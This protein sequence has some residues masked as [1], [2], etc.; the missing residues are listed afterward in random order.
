MAGRV[1]VGREARDRAVAEEI[2]LAVHE[3]AVVPAV[4]VAR[5]VEVRR[6]QRRVLARLPLA[7]LQ[8]PSRV[9]QLRVA[10][11]VIEVQVRR[12]EP[13]HARRIDVVAGEPRGE[14]L[15]R[16]ELDAVELREIAEPLGARVLLRRDVQARVEDD[17]AARV[18]DQ[19]GGHRDADRAALAG[20]E[21][22]QI[23][24]EPA[25]GEGEE[26][27]RHAGRR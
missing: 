10:A 13:A 24:L 19:P 7:A 16:R 15:A 18:E 9:R 27:E 25:A 14:L 11:D 6:A 26:T 3:D 8:H 5:V 17:R 2:V 12:D 1:A 4:E 20:H 21:H 22:A 23:G